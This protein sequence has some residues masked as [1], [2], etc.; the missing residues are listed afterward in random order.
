MSGQL[1]TTL[2]G[3]SVLAPLA[4]LE[5]RIE[6]R[7]RDIGGFGVRRVLPYVRRRHVG[8]F[9]FLDQMGP[10]ELAAGTGVDVPPHPHIGLA[11]VTY[12]WE[13]EIEHRDSVGS[14]RTI[15]PGEIN[16][17]TAG[18]G[19]VHSERTPAALRA[20]PHRLHGIQLWVALP[21][22]RE[23]MAPEFHHHSAAELPKLEQPGLVIRLLAGAAFGAT[24]PVR[25]YSPLAYADVEMEPGAQLPLPPE[26]SER[27]AY[28]VQGAL[29]LDGAQLAAPQLLV[30]HG[31]A[32][33]VLAVGKTRL[34]LL[35]GEPLGERH[36]WWNFV[37][38][39]PERIERAKQDWNEGRF[40]VLHGDPDANRPVQMT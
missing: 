23:E 16:W 2:Q 3:V 33:R 25:V 4:Q 30:F 13:G 35:A 14:F 1:Q 28:L 18:Q 11:T 38:S 21:R 40:P 26:Y 31:G 36:M 7:A 15:R 34:L 27:A 29:Q 10:A 9:V 6:P 5:T 17:M 12:L 24:A 32:A 37:S 8:P 39:S 22:E 20:G 19:I